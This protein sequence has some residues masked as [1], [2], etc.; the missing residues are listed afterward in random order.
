LSA[1]TTCPQCGRRVSAY[2][3]G[4]EGCGADLEAHARRARLA[5]ADAP[6]PRGASRLRA[7]LRR[8][9]DRL[10]ISRSEA[11]VVVLVLLTI[12]YLPA[13]ALVPIAL[14]IMH[15]VFEGRRGWTALF[16]VFAVLAL[17]LAVV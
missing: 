6:P 7:T 13:L 16:V 9:A 4:C 17:V 10:G 8:R 3:A 2:A 5:A 1:A 12:A 14:A 15:G 11:G